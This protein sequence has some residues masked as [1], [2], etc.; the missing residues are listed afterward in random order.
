MT[1]PFYSYTTLPALTDPQLGEV[2]V[3]TSDQSA[4]LRRSITNS[5]TGAISQG[6]GRRLV[7]DVS[8]TYQDSTFQNEDTTLRTVGG[9]GRLAYRIVD[10]LGLVAGYTY[11]E[12]MYRVKSVPS[13]V[14][15]RSYNFGLDFNKTMSA[16]RR[17]AFSF[18]TG[19]AVVE[20][21][22]KHGVYEFVGDARVVR[23]MSRSWKASASYRRGVGLVSGVD[24]PTL[25]NAVAVGLNGTMGRRLNAALVGGF[26]RDQIGVTV[27]QNMGNTYSGSASLSYAV[28]RLVSMTAAYVIYQYEF[29]RDIL[30]PEGLPPD[31][32]RQELRFGFDVS[33][34]LVR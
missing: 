20:D 6:L 29:D 15:V 2:T 19:T 3:K 27:A 7:A 16:S 21:S 4:S 17:T 26:S 14:T 31:F 30:L 22:D 32:K 13:N 1:S 12:G 33:L 18:H 10:G 24:T 34:P 23:Q 11:Q 5:S 28:S 8:G 25:S 9:A